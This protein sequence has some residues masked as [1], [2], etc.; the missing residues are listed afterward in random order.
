M[1]PQQLALLAVFAEVCHQGSITAAARSLGLSKGVVSTHVRTLES[2]LGVRLLNRTTRRLSVTD[3]GDA[4]LVL[5]NRIVASADEVQAVAD[6]QRNEPTGTLRVAATLDM[7][8]R[9]VAPALAELA[10]SHPALRAQ[11]LLDDHLID[12][13]VNRL[14]AT[15]RVGVQA[16]SSLTARLLATDTE[17][18][19]VAPSLRAAWPKVR[20]P[21]D[22]TAAPWI[23]HS[24]IAEQATQRFTSVQGQHADLKLRNVRIVANTTDA[25][26]V[27]VTAGAG[28]AVLPRHMV[29]SDLRERRMLQ[30]LPKWIRRKI[31]IDLLLPSRNNPPRRVVVFS[32]TLRKILAHAGLRPTTPGRDFK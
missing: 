15:V 22:L 5:A 31:R 2:H 30:I 19:V 8:A 4:V 13:V 7:G 1:N 16:D 3:S 28:F 21:A 12:P 6:A 9:F 27:L 10:R 17:I 23:I 18:I 11:L 20:K 14:D 24:A 26:R 25:I 29:A 32:E